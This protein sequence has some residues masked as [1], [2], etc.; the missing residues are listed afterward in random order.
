MSA[1]DIL[2]TEN[3]DLLT[4]TADAET[5]YGLAGNDTLDGQGEADVLDGGDGDDLYVADDLDTVIEAPDAG[6]DTVQSAFSHALAA[7]VENLFLTG[8]DAV[9]ATGNAL[10]NRLGGNSGNNLLDGGE[11]VDTVVLAPGPQYY[12]FTVLGSGLL[13]AADSYADNGD[14]GVDTLQGIERLEFGYRDWALDWSAPTVVVRA[15][16]L[17]D[18]MDFSAT[19]LDVVLDGDLGYDLIYGGQGNDVLR[20]GGGVDSLYGGGGNDTLSGV[21]FFVTQADDLYGGAGDDLYLVDALDVVHE[22]AGQG[23]DTVRASVSWTLSTSVE[24]LELSGGGDLEGV[25]NS[26]ANRLTGNSGANILSGGGGDDTYVVDGLDTV[27]ENDGEGIDTVQSTADV[28]LGDYLENLQLLGGEDINGT[29]NALDNRLTGNDGGNVLTGG[30]GNDVYDIDG[31][32]TVV[33]LSGQGTDTVYSAISYTLGEFVEH[34]VLTGA[35][36]L[37]ATGNAAANQLT[38][39]SGN[40]TL[41]GGGGNDLLAGGAGNDLYR[42]DQGDTVVEAAEAGSDEVVAAFSYTLGAHLEIL[43]LT[44]SAHLHGTGNALANTLTGNGGNNVLDGKEGAD[45][46]AGGLGYDTYYVDDAGDVIVEALSAGTDTVR[47]TVSYTLSANVEHLILDSDEA[48]DATGNDLKNRLTGNAAANGLDG[49]AGNDTLT[50]G[51]GDDRYYLDSR[52]DQVIELAG[53]GLDTVYSQVSLSALAD[54]V[55]NAWLL[56]AAAN[57]TGNALDNLLVG[58]A[59]G[60]QLTGGLGNDVLIGG[61]GADRLNGGEGDDEYRVGRGSAAD[62]LTDADATAGNA[63]VLLFDDATV[64]RDQLWFRQVNNDLEVRIMGTADRVTIKDWYVSADNRVEEI[65]TQGGDVLTAANVQALVS[66]MAVFSV[67]KLGR[68]E[69]TA[70]HHAALDAVIAASWS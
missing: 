10:D 52:Y 67:P 15:S 64:A 41:D 60:N 28:V 25:G 6:N 9:N 66:A 53:G 35:S 3:D 44:G 16:A 30:E 5:L 29:G 48:A 26:L 46:M 57:V 32:D 38:G 63:D 36:D 56:G 42:V 34:L 24:N 17:D 20:G 62:V 33:E 19:L 61:L 37:D 43:T 55:E 69:M 23:T 39:N 2:G 11:G 68:T 21:D 45:L 12:L 31:G 1:P 59:L 22:L 47:S 8:A 50:G 13:Q 27:Y 58:N 18:L 51:E 40:N 54:Q 70:T 65:R 7:N 4:G 49:G 14:D